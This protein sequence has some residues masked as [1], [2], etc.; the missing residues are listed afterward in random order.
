MKK[1]KKTK[2]PQTEEGRKQKC[3][4]KGT[5]RPWHNRNGSKRLATSRG[6]SGKFF[7]K[8]GLACSL[9]LVLGR[10]MNLGYIVVL[11]EDGDWS[12]LDYTKEIRGNEIVLQIILSESF[13][14]KEG[15][16]TGWTRTECQERRQLPVNLCRM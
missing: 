13:A 11:D 14:E 8:Y 16:E 12:R 4:R 1:K 5:Q 9:D 6:C 15:R 3:S 2:T 7:T 10:L